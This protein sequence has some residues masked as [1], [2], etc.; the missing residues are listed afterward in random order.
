MID[1]E[2][3]V[4]DLVDQ[5]GI[6]A[7]MNQNYESHRCVYMQHGVRIHTAS[8]MMNYLRTMMTIIED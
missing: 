4:D 2:S 7:E 6:I 8:S 1:A 3:Y 5:S